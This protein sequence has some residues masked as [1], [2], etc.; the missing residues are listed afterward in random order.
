MQ[1]GFKRKIISEE[2]TEIVKTN[3]DPKKE[4]VQGISPLGFHKMI[5]REWGDKNNPNVLVCVHGFGRNSND[6]D[7]LAWGL[8]EDI[9]VICPDV[10]GRG[11]SDY[12]GA[13]SVYTTVQYVNDMVTLLA[14]LNAKNL[15]WLGTSM[16][17]IIGMILA[18]QPKTPIK[19]LILNDVG[20]II[21]YTAVQRI[22][23]IYSAE[24]Y[25]FSNPEDAMAN[26]RSK[27]GTFGIV[28]PEHWDYMFE[29]NFKKNQGRDVS[30]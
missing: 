30:I 17:G 23:K 3:I 1:Q 16:G 15:Y 26:L 19:K 11:D 2:M 22:L 12:I 6:F 4:F 20:T 27:L 18:S 24:N 21:P 7:Y 29:H 8:Q 9:R 25:E 5:Y 14:R 13:P 28:K 10:I